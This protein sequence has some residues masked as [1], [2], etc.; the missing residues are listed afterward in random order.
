MKSHEVTNNTDNLVEAMSCFERAA[1]SRFGPPKKRIDN[2]REWI[3]TASVL[4]HPSLITAYDTAISLLSVVGGL[5]QTIERR[6]NSL[7]DISNL[8]LGAAAAAF[9]LNRV[10]KVVE[11]L[12]K[13]GRLDRRQRR[14]LGGSLVYWTFVFYYLL[15]K[16]SK[17]GPCFVQEALSRLLK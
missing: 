12:V 10:D 8:A 9:E 15:L 13:A 5:E 4:N 16:V 1:K 3:K 17:L 2:A 7:S 11:W 14:T 6:H